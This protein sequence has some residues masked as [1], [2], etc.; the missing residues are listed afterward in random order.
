MG[1]FISHYFILLYRVALSGA[2]QKSVL[3]FF[4]FYFHVIIFK[5]WCPPYSAWNLPI[6]NGLTLVLKVQTLGLPFWLAM[7]H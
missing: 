4:H 3:Y 5:M 1:V 6:I 2:P 7:S